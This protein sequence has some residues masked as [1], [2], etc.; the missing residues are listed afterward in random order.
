[1]SSLFDEK[2]VYIRTKAESEILLPQ[3]GQ[4]PAP[5]NGTPACG[6]HIWLD[7]RK[8]DSLWIASARNINSVP[9]S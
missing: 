6:L 2:L 7:V 1:M 4:D 8:G 5:V 9:G 3:L